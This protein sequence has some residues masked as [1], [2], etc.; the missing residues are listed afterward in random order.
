M[1]GSEDTKNK[2]KMKKGKGNEE[3]RGCF[4]NE[5]K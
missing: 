2:K 4:M 5:Q 1:K 3:E